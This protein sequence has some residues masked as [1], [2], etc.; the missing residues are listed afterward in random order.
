MNTS[1]RLCKMG[2]GRTCRPG[3][4][5]N[6]KPY[7]TCCGGCAKGQG[8][9][10]NCGRC[11]EYSMW[12]GTSRAAAY[13]IQKNGWRPSTGGALGPGVY[14]TRSK[15]KAMNYTKGSGRD[16]GAILELRV[17]TG[18]TKR[19]T[20]QG[21]S[22]RTTWA[23]AGYDSAYAPAGAVGQREED[24]IKNPANIQIVKVHVL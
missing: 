2:C 21:D 6:S 16:N 23:Q 10:S 13:D 5:K 22:L 9:E 19:I 11:L 4:Y 18:T 8:H 1:Q 24:C 12:H 3:L 15:A 20:G 17:K 14:V 7:D